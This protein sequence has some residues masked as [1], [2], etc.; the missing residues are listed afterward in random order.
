MFGCSSFLFQL[1]FR[2]DSL[3]MASATLMN[4]AAGTVRIYQ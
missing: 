4:V 1:S 2:D 3:A